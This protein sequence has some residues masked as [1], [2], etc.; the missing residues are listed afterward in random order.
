MI[1]NEMRKSDW[2]L[3]GGSSLDSVSNAG[4]DGVADRSTFLSFTSELDPDTKYAALQFRAGNFRGGYHIL[5][6]AL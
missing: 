5:R 3:G 6:R 2:D 1:H 4:R